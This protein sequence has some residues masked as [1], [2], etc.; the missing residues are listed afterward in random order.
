MGLAGIAEAKLAPWSRGSRARC[1]SCVLLLELPGL[2][3]IVISS[4]PPQAVARFA[5]DAL[6]A[7]ETGREGGEGV[8]DWSGSSTAVNNPRPK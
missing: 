3:G 8:H 2:S 4:S 1:P 7:C 6:L 5:W